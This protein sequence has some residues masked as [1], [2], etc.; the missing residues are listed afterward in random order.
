[1][2]DAELKELIV[3]LRTFDTD[4]HGVEVKLAQWAVPKNIWQTLSAFSNAPRGGILILGVREEGGFEAVGLADPGKTQSDLSSVCADMEPP[5]RPTISL[6]TFESATVLVAEIT[7]VRPDQK[8]CYFR[9][10]GLTNGAYTRVA[11]GDRRLTAYEVQ[12]LLAGH[13]QPRDDERPAP[14][15]SPEDLDPDLVAGLLGRLRKAE[16][17]PFRSLSDDD[18][19]RTL[20]VLI[21]FEDRLVPSLGGLLALGR[22]PQKFYPAL[23]LTFVVYPETEVGAPGPGGERFLDNRR[24][25]GP[26]PRVIQP[27]LE[28]LQRNMKRRSRV[29]GLFRED[30]WEYPET[31]IREAVVNA[32][33]HRDLSPMSQGSPVQIQMFPD[34]LSIINPGGLFGPVTVDRLGEAGISSSRN[35]TLMKLLEDVVVP[36][37]D[38]AICENRGSGIGAMLAALRDA[39]MSPPAFEDEI[40]SF[41]LTFPNHSLLDA[42]TL[43]WLEDVGQGLLN[44]SQAMGLAVLRRVGAI[45]NSDYRRIS[46]VDSRLATRELGDLVRKGVLIQLGTRGAASYR[47][48]T[49]W[50]APIEKAIIGPRDRIIRA[51][52][53]DGE[54]SRADLEQTL[55]MRRE[56]VLYYLNQLI[57]LGT[58][59]RTAPAR[60]PLSRYRIRTLQTTSHGS[61]QS[62]QSPTQLPLVSRR[63][64]SP[65]HDHS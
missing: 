57:E 17:S 56:T 6:H 2:D 4:T 3:G 19:L 64:R 30:L 15:S 31:A 10:Q 14:D 60:S 5:I 12:L 13:G 37:E 18:A 55:G 8:P 61:A 25:D 11:D 50:M 27:V 16:R 38:R 58:I 23:S 28:A 34:R 40:A 54:L 29:R 1:M 45:N 49:K 51:L 53:R 41:R 33:G 24:I 65:S 35:A 7:E 62:A 36:G 21:P 48:A 9:P 52:V 43:S 44:D 63:R 39:G 26:I 46:G 20:K 32:L 59:E 22:Y 42:E 47:L